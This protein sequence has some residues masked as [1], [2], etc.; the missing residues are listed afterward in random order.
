MK[1]IAA[2]L[3]LSVSIS[4]FAAGPRLIEEKDGSE[5]VYIV[6]MASKSSSGDVTGVAEKFHAKIRQ[7]YTH[8]LQGFSANM[9][10]ADALA[11][12]RDS[13]I[14][15]VEQDRPMRPTAVQNVGTYQLDRIDQWCPATGYCN[16]YDYQYTY[17]RTGAGVRLYVIDSG[18]DWKPELANVVNGYTDYY[19]YGG[20][21]D[22][23]DALGHGTAVASLAGGTTNGA[24]KGVTLVN[25]KVFD[26]SPAT[27]VAR[28]IAGLD[29]VA[30]DH[31][32]HPTVPAVANISTGFYLTTGLN[33]LT[34][35]QVSAFEQAVI[36]TIDAGVVVVCGAGN[37]YPDG[38]APQAPEPDDDA[39]ARTP[40]RLNG[41]YSI[42]G[43][44]NPRNRTTITVGA[45]DYYDH[46]VLNAFDGR[47]WSTATGPCVDLFAPGDHVGASTPSGTFSGTSASSPIVA[48]V[49]ALYL[50]G[51]GSNYDPNAVKAILMRNNSQSI[52]VVYSRVDLWQ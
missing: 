51:R 16:L 47:T 52:R 43:V 25:V 20:A 49:V 22:Y 30:A 29:W 21:P 12:S 42:P 7:R 18:I 1:S 15:S 14:K 31:R 38:F 8:V 9:A 28:M 34:P 50:E 39:C 2:A 46:P 13:R 41:M 32:A 5:H 4:A 33:S 6:Q 17:F 3:C 24:A 36:N 19:P 27:T 10:P 45:T 40:A 35:A 11:M 37:V 26:T 48:G 44:S 23:S